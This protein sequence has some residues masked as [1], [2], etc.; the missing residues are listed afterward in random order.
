[1][2]HVE[3]ILMGCATTP[4]ARSSRVTMSL[5]LS[6][7][8]ISHSMPIRI[9]K[10]ACA[11]IDRHDTALA[12]RS[13]SC[14]SSSMFTMPICRPLYTKHIRIIYFPDCDAREPQACPRPSKQRRAMRGQ[15]RQCAVAHGQRHA[16]R[17]SCGIA[18]GEDPWH[19]RLLCSV[20]LDELAQRTFLDLAAQLLRHRAAEVGSCLGEQAIHRQDASVCQHHV[21]LAFDALDGR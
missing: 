19:A 14:K 9:Q 20:D 10:A 4:A 8:F 11:L 1:L 12:L 17:R 3:P 7:G 16:A 6:V 13:W 18:T 2:G 5:K 21:S 15:A